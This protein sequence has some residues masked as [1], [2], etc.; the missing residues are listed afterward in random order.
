LSFLQKFNKSSGYNKFKGKFPNSTDP[1]V[2]LVERRG[3]TKIL[4]T[5]I[6]AEVIDFSILKKG[7]AHFDGVLAKWDN[8]LF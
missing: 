3:K 5:I 7:K 4:Q 6:I 1:W 2:G 8:F